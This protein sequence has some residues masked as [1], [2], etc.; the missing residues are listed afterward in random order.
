ML[1]F[2]FLLFQN[3]CPESYS[4]FPSRLT[5][6]WFDKMA[7]LGY[8]RPLEVT[9]LWELNPTERSNLVTPQFDRY[10]DKTM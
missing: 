5:Y 1:I 7:L 2:L 10:W 6:I 3:A 9:D 4:S 8:R